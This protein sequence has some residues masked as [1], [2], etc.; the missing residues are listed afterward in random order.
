MYLKR[1]R[2]RGE[3]IM[4]T[5]KLI[6]R[7]EGENEIDLETL[8][9]SLNSTVDTLKR[10]ANHLV[11]ENDYCK[12]KVLSIEKGSFV[13]VIS[14]IIDLAPAILP[15]LPT[16]IAAFKEILEIR[17]LLQGEPPTEIVRTSQGVNIT[18]TNGDVYCAQNIVFNMYDNNVEKSMSR[19]AK[20]VLE[21]GN[22]TGITYEIEQEKS[23]EK[24]QLDKSSL[25]ALSIPQDVEKFDKDIEENETITWVKVRKPDLKG[26]TQWGLTLE[27]R[28][29][30]CAISDQAFLDKVHNNEI[31]FQSNTRLYVKMIVRYK[32]NHTDSSV[33]SNIISR[34]IIEVFNV[35]N[36]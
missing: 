22:R 8:T 31:T 34:N 25:Q 3:F 14:Q 5:E 12:F 1:S 24:I 6:M 16:V 28:N 15:H 18:N 26:D 21:D 10:L 2:F 11:G 32:N 13:V 35:E 17:N 29:I 30:S 4:K 36:N 33:S 7:F 20:A 19:V 9:N 27:G 23:T